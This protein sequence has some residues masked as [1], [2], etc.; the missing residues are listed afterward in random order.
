MIDNS[1]LT[2]I[3]TLALIQIILLLINLVVLVQKAVNILDKT[4]KKYN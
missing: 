1:L 4:E 3:V 2:T